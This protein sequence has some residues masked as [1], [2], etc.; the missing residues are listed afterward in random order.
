M[1]NKPKNSTE[2]KKEIKSTGEA[3][4]AQRKDHVDNRQ[5]T[6]DLAYTDACARIIKINP[7]QLTSRRRQHSYLNLLQLQ[8]QIQ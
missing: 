4:I 7:F 8:K 6:H 2:K 1:K 3:G 5:Q